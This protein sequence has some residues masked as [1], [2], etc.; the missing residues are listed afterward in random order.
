MLDLTH[1]QGA[2]SAAPVARPTAMPD[3][4]VFVPE[5]PRNVRT[6]RTQMIFI[7]MRFLN[8]NKR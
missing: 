5:V 8:R 1:S 3:L 4:P 7:L 2:P 6:S